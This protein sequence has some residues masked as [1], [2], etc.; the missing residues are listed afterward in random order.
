MVKELTTIK[1]QV[2]NEEKIP[3]EE[4]KMETRVP[5]IGISSTIVVGFNEE[6]RLRD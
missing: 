1:A 2:S 6:E 3:A 5:K 4:T